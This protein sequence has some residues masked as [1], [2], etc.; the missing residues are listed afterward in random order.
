MPQRV[1]FVVNAA[2]GVGEDITAGI[3]VTGVEQLGLLEAR[4]CLAEQ[5]RRVFEPAQLA[6]ESD[7]SSVIHARRTEHAHGVA[8]HCCNHLRE[9][10]GVERPGE[11]YARDFAYKGGTEGLDV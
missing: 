4:H 6:A 2:A 9:A 10:A 3:E 11:V 5:L 1:T 8:V 7:V